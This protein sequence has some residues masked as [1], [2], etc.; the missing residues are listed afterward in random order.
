VSGEG[1]INAASRVTREFSV[2]VPV[3][4]VALVVEL[5]EQAGLLVWSSLSGSTDLP[6]IGQRV[7]AVYHPVAEDVTLIYFEQV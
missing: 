6:A 5:D 3:P 7:R 1:R 4:Y 2:G